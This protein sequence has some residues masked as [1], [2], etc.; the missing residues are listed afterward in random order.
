VGTAPCPGEDGQGKAPLSLY[1][2]ELGQPLTG[3][4]A[5]TRLE[6][7]SGIAR[8]QESPYPELMTT[9]VSCTDEKRPPV[10]LP[11]LPD[12]FAAALDQEQTNLSVS[13]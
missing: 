3:W 5:G 1:Y 10:A 6:R 8:R 4:R 7:R 2:R 9:A 13:N 11:A 12:G